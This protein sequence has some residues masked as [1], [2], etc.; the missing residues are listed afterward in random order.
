MKK[1]V[2]SKAEMNECLPIYLIQ[3]QM[4]TDS[5]T[6]IPT[7]KSHSVLSFIMWTL[8]HFVFHHRI[9]DFYENVAQQYQ[10]LLKMA[11][12]CPELIL[13]FFF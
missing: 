11:Q 12:T 3:V 5:E 7:N 4:P 10:L 8:L 1:N 9:T 13:I 6:K 2:Q